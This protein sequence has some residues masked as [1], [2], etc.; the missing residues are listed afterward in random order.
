M[1]KDEVGTWDA[2]V[3][4]YMAGPDAPPEVSDGVETNRMLGELWLISEFEGGF[5]GATFTGHGLIGFDPRADRFV[6]S[7]AD[8]MS[9]TLLSLQGTYDPAT[10]TMTL[11]GT[12]FDPDCAKSIVMLAGAT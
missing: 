6:M 1:L 2:K 3:K 11:T 9:T 5:G 7:W 4:F 10:R 8:S 12:T